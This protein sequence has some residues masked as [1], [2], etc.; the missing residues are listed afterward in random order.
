MVMLSSTTTTIV[1]GDMA[2]FDITAAAYDG[3]PAARR[4]CAD[5][6]NDAAGRA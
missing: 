2:L 6:I 1:T 4:A 3:D 5:A